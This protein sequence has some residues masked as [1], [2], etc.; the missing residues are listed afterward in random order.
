LD[1]LPI[2][3]RTKDL[4]NV[5]AHIE[6]G[7][8]REHIDEMEAT[9]IPNYCKHH[10]FRLDSLSLHFRNLSVSLKPDQLVVH[11][12]IEPGLIKGHDIVAGSLLLMLQHRKKLS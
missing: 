1:V 2:G 11:I 9:L 4:S 7:I 5:I 6:I 10:L 12:E 3:E 8:F